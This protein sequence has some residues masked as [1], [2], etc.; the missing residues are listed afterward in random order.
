V[1]VLTQQPLDDPTLKRWINGWRPKGSTHG[2]AMD[3]ASPQLGAPFFIDGNP[4]EEPG[5][6]GVGL[7]LIAADARLKSTDREYPQKLR[8]IL[9]NLQ[10]QIGGEWRIEE[11]ELE[12]FTVQPIGG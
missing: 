3:Q 9:D 8:R 5:V 1:V 10:T 12:V 4:Q 6:N 7:T 2:F 11:R